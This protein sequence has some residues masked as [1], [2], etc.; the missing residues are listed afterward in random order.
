MESIGKAAEWP[1]QGLTVAEHT[2]ALFHYPGS[3]SLH[4]LGPTPLQG[5]GLSPMTP[6]P[7][8]SWASSPEPQGNC[9]AVLHCLPSP[10]YSCS[11]NIRAP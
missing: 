7:S 1:A 6:F 8:Q 9:Q 5:R 10:T 3:H 4:C 11:M 2:G